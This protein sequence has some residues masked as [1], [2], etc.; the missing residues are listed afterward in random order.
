M[1]IVAEICIRICSYIREYI[2]YANYYDVNGG[3]RWWQ[4]AK[5]CF[6]TNIIT[7]IVILLFVFIALVRFAMT[8]NFILP[9]LQ[10][11]SYMPLYWIFMAAN[12][13]FS[14][15]HYANWIRES[16]GLDYAEGSF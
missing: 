9:P 6:S 16:H 13:G 15:L 4:M 10:W 7:I 12:I 3:A 1:V 2:W 11:F 5:R 8:T 14:H